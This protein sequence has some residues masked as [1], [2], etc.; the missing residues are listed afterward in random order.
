MDELEF[1]RREGRKCREAA[2]RTAD[3][4]T[5]DSM[6]QLARGYERQAALIQRRSVG[7]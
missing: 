7:A 3:R 5:R 4:A 1:L 2:L 6:E